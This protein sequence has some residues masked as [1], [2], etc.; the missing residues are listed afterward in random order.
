MGG[1]LSGEG[2]GWGIKCLSAV[3]VGKSVKVIKWCGQEVCMWLV[4]G[5]VCG[6][7]CVCVCVWVVGVCVC[8]CV[9]GWV[10]VC[11]C[12]C[13]CVCGW[14]GGVCVCGWVCGWEGWLGLNVI[15]G[16]KSA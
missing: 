10:G 1:G 11:V 8:V 4:C 3:W 13:V 16:T 9:G 2:Q 6:G 14:V 15:N 12:V 7:V 5:C